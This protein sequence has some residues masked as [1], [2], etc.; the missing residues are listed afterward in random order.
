M[1]KSFITFN[2]ADILAE[3][4]G[5]KLVLNSKTKRVSLVDASDP[6][7][8]CGATR[9]VWDKVAEQY[10]EPHILEAKR[11]RRGEQRGQQ[12]HFLRGPIPMA[13]LERA[14]QLPGKAVNVAIALWYVRG[15]GQ[16]EPFKLKRET[17]ARFGVH[18]RTIYYRA[19]LKLEAAGLIQVTRK[20]GQAA[21]VA[22]LLDGLASHE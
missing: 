5:V 16:P 8:D 11:Q 3:S 1:A 15:F 9:L 17:L 2:P 10:V 7:A 4:G 20:P 18:H 22:V 19:L 13:W 21:S 12:G 6:I 14:C